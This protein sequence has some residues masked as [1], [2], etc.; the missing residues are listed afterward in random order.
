MTRR[1]ITVPIVLLVI[2]AALIATTTQFTIM[3]NGPPPGPGPLPLARVA[4]AL[5]GGVVPPSAQRRMSITRTSEDKFGREDE[6]PSPARDAAIARLI[7]VPAA[8]VHGLYQFPARDPDQ[9]MH[10]SFTVALEDGDGWIIAS[11]SFRPTFTPWHLARL[12]GM[13]AVLL[14]L[15]LL[16]WGVARRISRPIRELAGAATRMRLGARQPIPDKGPREVHE[17]AR[18]LE[19]MQE[20]ILHEAENRGAMLGAIAHDL[21]TPLSRIAFWVEQLPD[22]ARLR[23]EADIEEM[24]AMLKAALRFT[25]DERSAA[26]HQKL[27]LGSLI[28]SLV[29]DLAAAGTPVEVESGPR[30]VVRGD[31]AQLRRLFTNLI[32]NAVRYGESARLHWR[33][34]DGKVDVLV[35]DDGPGFDPARAEALFA[36][37]VR[38]EASRNRETGG[39]GLGLAIVRSITEAHGGEVTLENRDGGGRVRVRLPV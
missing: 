10:G 7:G 2:A 6:R 8:R 34:I 37:F 5:K 32:E 39:T 14:V 30:A 27:D 28:E 33:P 15:S 18:A 9:D 17:L 4:E 25:R 31:P 23:A 20:R 36:P 21:G 26:P 35:E 16:A 12:M 29:E 11:S 38:G 24:R 1:S 13:L 3:F 19:S 22:A